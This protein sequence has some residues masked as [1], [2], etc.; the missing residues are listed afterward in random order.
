MKKTIILAGLV[1]CTFS[2]ASAAPKTQQKKGLQAGPGA[3]SPME[4]R[5]ERA[6]GN[7]EASS[8]RIENA[9]RASRK[10]KNG[11][12]GSQPA[13]NGHRVVY[14]RVKKCGGCGAQGDATSTCPAKPCGATS[15][16]PAKPCGETSSASQPASSCRVRKGCSKT[17]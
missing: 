12:E 2:A 9:K 11:V 16:C 14:K 6:A 3:L 4:A 17:P 8:T 1:L 7:T 15:T 5:I 10:I 13:P